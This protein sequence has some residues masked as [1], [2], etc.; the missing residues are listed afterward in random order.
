M[1]NSD[2]LAVV[3]GGT[4]G[5]GRATVEKLDKEGFSIAT[6]ARNE[7]DLLDLKQRLETDSQG[8]VYTYAA[9]LSKRDEVTD[10]IEFLRLIG[11][12]VE[13]LVNNTGVFTPGLI[14]EEEEGA[15]EHM[16]NTNVYSAYHLSRGLVPQM[17]KE[18]RG[19]VF[20][21]CS[22]ASL[23]AYPNG[24]SYSISKFAMYGFSQVLREEL[25]EDGV[26]VTSILAGAVKTPSWDGVDLP[27]E[28]FMRPEDIAETIWN[29]YQ[30]SDR[31]V[32]EDIVLRP[33]LGEFT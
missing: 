2:H 7:E 24:G 20:N 17:Q 32:I 11:K 28:R 21:V 12:N 3:T 19:H 1:D 14:L 31:T 6:C 25:K 27:D 10:F 30:L 4:K 15:L 9:D 26:R 13:V 5:I 18:K 29:T 33:Q 8:K 16:I 23:K 22:V